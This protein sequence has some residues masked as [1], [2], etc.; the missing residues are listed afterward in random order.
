MDDSVFALFVDVMGVQRELTRGDVSQPVVERRCRE[1]FERFHGDLFD[2][3]NLNFPMMAS[4]GSVEEPSF[5]AEF[6]DAAYVVGPRFTTVAAAGLS[7]MRSALRHRYPLRGGIGIGS[8]SHETSGVR[9]IRTG[10]VWSTSSFFGSSVVTAYQAE[11]SAALG[12][13]IFVHEAAV[14]SAKADPT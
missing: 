10:Q 6:S 12:L 13:R 3:I 4:G 8:F 7:L 9:T 5:I 14:E 1:V 11:R 2:T